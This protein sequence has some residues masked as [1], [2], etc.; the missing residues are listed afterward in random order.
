MDS[1]V[2]SAYNLARGVLLNSRLTMADSGNQPLKLLDIVVSGMGMDPTTGLWLTPLHGIPAVPRVFPFDLICLDK[3]YRVVQTA[4]MGPGIEF[5][6]IHSEIASALVLPSDTLRSTKTASGDRLIVC[7]ATELEALLTST[8]TVSGQSKIPEPLAPTPG[9]V[10]HSSEDSRNA[11]VMEFTREKPAAAA[12]PRIVPDFENSIH[13]AVA[14]TADN[15]PVSEVDVAF[16]ERVLPPLPSASHA[17]DAVAVSRHPGQFSPGPSMDVREAVFDFVRHIP[18]TI[19]EHH[20]D[21]EDLFSNW[22]VSTAPVQASQLE[23]PPSPAAVPVPKPVSSPR[24]GKPNGSKATAPNRSTEPAELP[25]TAAQEIAPSAVQPKSRAV[26][27]ASDKPGSKSKQNSQEKPKAAAVSRLAIPQLPPA[28]TFTAVPYGMWQVSM[29]TAVAPL[30]TSGRPA[31]PAAPLVRSTGNKSV[32]AKSGPAASHLAKLAPA[33]EKQS[34]SAPQG[35]TEPAARPSVQDAE[36]Q[37]R[38]QDG[39]VR[40][41]GNLPPKETASAPKPV[42]GA[43]DAPEKHTPGDFVASLQEKLQRVQQGKPDHTVPGPDE[44]PEKS[45]VATLPSAT[46]VNKQSVSISAPV[47]PLV[48]VSH[49][50][51]S[52][53]FLSQDTTSSSSEPPKRRASVTSNPAPQL[54]PEKAEKA[55]VELYASSFRTRFKQWLNPM[56]TPSD[57]RRNGR[58]YVPGMV[59]HYFTG[60][61]PK[62]HE[63]ADISMTGMYLLTEDRWMP[64]TMIQMTLQKPCARGE[65]K[66][67]INVL[68]RIVRRGSDGV[69]A[70]FVMAETLSRVSHDIQP[71]QATDKFAL[72]RFL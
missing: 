42:M 29:P 13:T 1:R 4:E 38:T 12:G 20:I 46:L 41:S 48:P 45:S 22:V 56:A 49:P 25:P 67:S 26:S 7:M 54:R 65:R 58:R 14:K 53:K 8:Y 59:A 64:G 37:T 33:P 69:A 35:E 71:S 52:S 34:F 43:Q 28:N 70:E 17:Q 11:T 36:S 57:R 40:T 21:P 50:T 5:P 60:G 3:D 39:S 27:A 62:P 23:R 31:S 63:V 66:Q 72:A 55:K 51:T 16:T 24:N 2:F 6:A 18:A 15:P 44:L 61:A 10:L 30:A 68:S 47:Q 19:V 9:V 32:E